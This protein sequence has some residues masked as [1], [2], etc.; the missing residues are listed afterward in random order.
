MFETTGLRA[1]CF[2]PVETKH[3]ALSTRGQPDDVNPHR[4]TFGT[5][6]KRVERYRALTHATPPVQHEIVLLLL[7]EVFPLRHLRRSVKKKSG[8]GGS[9]ARRR[10]CVREVYE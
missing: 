5:V 8:C 2:E 9:E 1:L 10:E 6:Y 3:Q 4:L 7:L